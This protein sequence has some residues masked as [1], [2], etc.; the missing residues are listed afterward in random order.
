MNLGLALA[1]V[2]FFLINLRAGHCYQR[3][4]ML[5][6]DGADRTLGDTIEDERRP[7]P[8]D[9]AAQRFLKTDVRNVLSCL[10]EREQEVIRLRYGRLD[11]GQSMTLAQAGRMLQLTP[12]RIRQL[13]VRAIRKLRNNDQISELKAYLN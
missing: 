4:S 2:N 11:T 7:P 13:E 1:T 9:D 8:D 3:V 10:T 12:E 5:T 6:A